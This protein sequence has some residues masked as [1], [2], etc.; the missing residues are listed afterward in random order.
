MLPSLQLHVLCFAILTSNVLA[1]HPQY[2]LFSA[3][4]VLSTLNLKASFLT[5]S[6]QGPYITSN[7]LR[8]ERQTKCQMSVDDSSVVS[9]RN[10]L[11]GFSYFYTEAE[12][13][14]GGTDDFLAAAFLAAIPG[15][16][17]AADG[18]APKPVVLESGLAYVEKKKKDGILASVEQKVGQVAVSSR[19]V[20]IP[21]ALTPNLARAILL[22]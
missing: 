18:G 7:N 4:V 12:S 1:F 16:T 8:V 15:K 13:H 3:K 2:M 14:L 17:F 21:S 22:L 9:R 5:E 6:Y 19:P 20:L 11:A 10:V